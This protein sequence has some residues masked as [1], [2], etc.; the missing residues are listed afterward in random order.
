M[1]LFK[2]ISETHHILKAC[3]ITLFLVPFW[4]LSI[5]LFNNQF[6]YDTDLII[7]IVVCITLSLSSS[8]AF[9]IFV[10]TLSDKNPK[11]IPYEIAISTMFLIVWKC[12]LMFAAYSFCFFSG[13]QLYYYWYIVIYF[14]PIIIFSIIGLATKRK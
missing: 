9:Y 13:N 8:F 14:V 5:F 2:E 7:K 10:Y 6:Y 4:Y 1:T 3:A 12:V 11:N